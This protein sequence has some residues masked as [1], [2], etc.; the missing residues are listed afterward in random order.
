LGA[1]GYS[2]AVTGD[3]DIPA[4]RAG[5]WREARRFADAYTGDPAYQEVHEYLDNND[6]CDERDPAA[7]RWWFKDLGSCCTRSAAAWLH[8]LHLTVAVE[9]D[10]VGQ[11]AAGHGVTITAPR[12]AWDGGRERFVVLRGYLWTAGATG[13]FGDDRHL[14][15]TALTDLERPRFDESLRGCRCRICE[16]LRG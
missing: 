14:P 13:L 4:L 2:L 1:I 6:A 11:L 12:P 16:V 10:R 9:W 15:L 8:W 7:L 5:I 3:G